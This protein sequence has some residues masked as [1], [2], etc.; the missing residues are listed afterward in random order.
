ML[1]HHPELR[2][3]ADRSVQLVLPAAIY[4]N[5]NALVAGEVEWNVSSVRQSGQS[6]LRPSSAEAD[7]GSAPM[8]TFALRNISFFGDTGLV[9]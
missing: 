5:T 1:P 9:T 2:R 4:T 8:E 3:S 7:V 6:G